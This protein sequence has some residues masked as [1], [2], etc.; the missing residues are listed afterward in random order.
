MSLEQAVFL[1]LLNDHRSAT[2]PKIFAATASNIELAQLLVEVMLDIAAAFD[3]HSFCQTA[4][5]T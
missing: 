1:K 5:S 4:Y 3:I 2:L